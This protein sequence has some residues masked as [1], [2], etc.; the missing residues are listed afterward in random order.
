LHAFVW[1]KPPGESDGTSAA[2]TNDQGKKSDPMC[3]PTF[4]TPAGVLT[5]ALPNAP[6]AGQWFAAQLVELVQ[7]ADPAVP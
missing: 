6:L 2:T 4:T 1:V 5:G 3:N 7:N